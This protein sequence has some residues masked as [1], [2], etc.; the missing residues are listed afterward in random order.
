MKKTLFIILA[1]M[2]VCSP[3][4]A[5][6]AKE[7]ESD[8]P[9]I[10]YVTLG[11]TGMSLL[12]Q[13]A[14][15]FE[16]KTGIKVKLESWA[17]S[18]AYQKVLTLAGGNNLPDAMYGFS[19]WI[20]EFKEA[21]YTVAVDELISKALYDDFSKASREV[22]SLDGK[23]WALPSYMSIRGMLFNTKAFSKAGVAIP[24]EN[25]IRLECT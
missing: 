7:A 20:P 24:Y 22:C 1:V 16:A 10:T 25:K 8:S 2:L 12:E 17:Y 5:S 13:A 11:D 9:T 15:D 21:G 19:S 4:F 18:D 23:L 3:I 14:K 6:G